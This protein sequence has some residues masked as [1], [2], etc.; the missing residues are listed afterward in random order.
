MNNLP[1]SIQIVSYSFQNRF[2]VNANQ[3]YNGKPLLIKV[4]TLATNGNFK[5]NY[6]LDVVFFKIQ[7]FTCLYYHFFLK[8]KVKTCYYEI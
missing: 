6:Y 2:L 4:C 3:Y 5:H 1:M 7:S 8:I